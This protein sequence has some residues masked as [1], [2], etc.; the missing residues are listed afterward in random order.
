M[1]TII[2]SAWQGTKFK[3]NS[4]NCIKELFVLNEVGHFNA[5]RVT[6]IAVMILSVVPNYFAGQANLSTVAAVQ[7]KESRTSLTLTADLAADIDVSEEKKQH[8]SV[9]NMSFLSPV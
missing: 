1:L 7:D 9:L 4:L 5:Y 6:T 8:V 3:E 2:C